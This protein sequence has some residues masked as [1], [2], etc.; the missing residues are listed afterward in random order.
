[1]THDDGRYANYKA[2]GAE[3]DAPGW[4]TAVLRSLRAA[5]GQ[6]YAATLATVR[7]LQR[8][9]VRLVVKL[10]SPDVAD[11]VQL[12]ARLF[13]DTP[14][15]PAELQL[16]T[17]A[18]TLLA[19]EAN[20]ALT[21]DEW[22]LLAQCLRTL[23]ADYGRDVLRRMV[24]SALQRRQVK[25]VA[26]PPVETAAA[27]AYQVQGLVGLPVPGFGGLFAYLSMG[28]A[29][30]V[31]IL[32]GWVWVAETRIDRLKLEGRELKR[33][34]KI[35]EA[36]AK[37][38]TARAIDAEA[39]VGQANASVAETAKRATTVNQAEAKRQQTASA[40]RR[41][42]EAKRAAERSQ[43][44][45]SGIG[46]PDQWLRDLAVQP[47]LSAPAVAAPDAASGAGDRHS[48]ELPGSSG[49]ETSAKR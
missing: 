11:A 25:V 36:D 34:T 35:V 37:A 27:P 26:P 20:D 23:R 31:V 5:Y 28:L 7:K 10:S 40:M 3:E 46:D 42:E 44:P 32:G 12:Q 43:N 17:T 30:L 22:L 24:D 13:E 15:D 8:L 19:K 38:A 49:D 45:D 4:G 21:N 18:A 41:R 14:K 29:V 6:A 1:M 9:Q 16:R 2:F 33:Y 47:L 39:R 48:G